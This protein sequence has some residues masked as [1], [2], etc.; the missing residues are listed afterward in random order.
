MDIGKGIIAGF[1]ATVVLS[2]I[3]LMKAMIGFMP[4]LDII[5]MMSTMMGTG[6]VVA[7]VVHFAIGT[8]M[9]GILFAWL[10]PKLPGGSHWLKGVIFGLGAWLV[11]MIVMMPMAGQ[12]LFGLQLGIMAPIMTAM[13]HAIFGAVLGGVYGA[14]LGHENQRAAH[15]H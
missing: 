1:V 15:Q 14:L 7:W 8:L 3:M 9:W 6:A 12:G 11:M 13:L 10:G 4:E 2:A 5:G